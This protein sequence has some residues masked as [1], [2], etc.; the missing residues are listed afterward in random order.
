MAGLFEREDLFDFDEESSL[1]YLEWLLDGKIP[2]ELAYR[3]ETRNPCDS[4]QAGTI[5]IL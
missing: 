1:S 3:V 4:T 5:A 2:F